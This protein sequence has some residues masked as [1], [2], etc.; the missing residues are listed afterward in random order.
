[1][2]FHPALSMTPAMCVMLAM[3]TAGRMS[4][5]NITTSTG[6]LTGN[7]GTTVLVQFNVS[8]ENSWRIN[9]EF[10]DAAW[11]FVKYRASDGIWRHASLSNTGHVAPAGSTITAGLLTPGAAYNATTNPGVG[12]FLYR[13]ADGG[14]TF[15]ANGVQ[16]LWNYS[17]NGVGLVDVK[18]VRVFAIEMTNAPQTAYFVGETGA[19]PSF[20]SFTNGSVVSGPCIA[21]QITSESA[22]TVAQTAGALWAGDGINIGGAG[23]LSAA[24]PKGFKAIY[25]MKYEVTQQGYVDFLNTLTYDQQAGLT[26]SPNSPA[27]TGALSNSY[28]NGIDIQTPGVASTTPA[29][30]ACNLNG[31][32][33]YGD[34]ADGKD[35]ACNHLEWNQLTAYLDWCGLRPMTEMEYE[36]ICRGPL[37]TVPSYPWGTTC[38]YVG[39]GPGITLVNQGSAN[40]GVTLGYVSCNANTSWSG[41]HGPVRVGLYAANAANTGRETAGAGYYGNMELGGNVWE[42]VVTVGSTEGRAFT[43]THGN[44]ALAS[45]GQ[46]DATSWP[47]V[48][49]GYGVRGGSFDLIEAPL[50][51]SFRGSAANNSVS[52]PYCGGRGVRTQ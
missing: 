46:A 44:G 24:Y 12:V 47:N 8:W 25:S 21:L 10:W 13:N 42:R 43:G 45:N 50:L 39:P 6:T 52:T 18:E 37:T 7:S 29:V 27:G 35:I 38:I 40:E 16:L 31:D 9:P 41:I 34:A 32:A 22:L 23:T 15:A 4:A 30:Y 33:T 36:K 17:V 48:S 51:V 5:N 14:G 49:A 1:M 19:P 28:R 11:I 2:K 20:G 3:L 26:V